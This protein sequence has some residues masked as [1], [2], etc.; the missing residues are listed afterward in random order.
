MS[1]F[2]HKKKLF[3]K[4]EIHD[5]EILELSAIIQNFAKIEKK[6]WLEI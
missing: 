4:V 5:Y 6:N 3:K 1:I 2:L